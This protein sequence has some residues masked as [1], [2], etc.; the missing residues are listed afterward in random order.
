MA[1]RSSILCLGHSTPE[2]LPLNFV[3]E[4]THSG[5]YNTC[6]EG[7]IGVLLLGCTE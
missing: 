6:I 3:E 2:T 4:S 1:S 5:P 7:D